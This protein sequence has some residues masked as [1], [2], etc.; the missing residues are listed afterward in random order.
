MVS[1]PVSE[2]LALER[3]ARVLA[4]WQASANADG[5]SPSAGAQV[6]RDW[7]DQLDPALAILKTLREPDLAMA[8][9]GDAD[10]WSRMVDAAIAAR[11]RIDLPGADFPDLPEVRNAG[12]PSLAT[13]TDERSDES[14]P[15]SDP[16]PANPGVG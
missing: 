7:A 1:A 11:P 2:T 16:P 15:A 13:D 6:D 14:F 4:G 9:A 12:H 5:T 8:A 10:I 3:I